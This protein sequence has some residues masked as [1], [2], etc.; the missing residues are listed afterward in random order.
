M[1]AFDVAALGIGPA[2]VREAVD[3]P[4]FLPAGAPDRWL[5]GWHLR[6]T[7]SAFRGQDDT[8][9]PGALVSGSV[10]VTVDGKLLT[11][12]IDYMVDEKWSAVSRAGDWSGYAL[13]SYRYRLRRI[14][15]LIRDDDG[16]LTVVAGHP[17][18]STPL[19]P[20]VSPDRHVA[21]VFVDGDDMV[22]LPIGGQTWAAASNAQLALLPTLSA[23]LEAQSRPVRVTCWGD[24]VTAGGSSSSRWSA[25][26]LHID[27]AMNAAGIPA[28]VT[29]VAIGGTN[30]SQ[31]LAGAV[32]EMS[33]D[34][35]AASRPDVLVV[36]FVNDADLDDEQLLRNYEEIADLCR[37][38][39]CDLILSTPHFVM[40]E[41]MQHQKITQ[42]D[43]RPYVDFLRRFSA[44]R[45]IALAEVARAWESL[46]RFG[47]P[48]PSLLSNGINHP[49]DRGHEIYANEILSVMGLPFEAAGGSSPAGSRWMAS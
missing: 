44:Q 48:Y 1:E 42:P 5:S 25:Y 9:V 36:E 32:S 29:T 4:C 2:D 34:R 40:P 16:A 15:A 7:M 35:V 14:D 6:G 10:R 45:G 49:D 13:I 39:N 8:P 23:L 11:V 27:R 31:W 28:V 41:W 24:S 47:L 46:W 21:N 22:V 17:H 20:Q 30:T 18:L 43:G 38:W 33:I 12:G 19:P 26:P 37:S 3:E